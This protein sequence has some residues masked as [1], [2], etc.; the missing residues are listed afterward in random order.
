MYII[1]MQARVGGT[2]AMQFGAV[3]GEKTAV[4]SASRLHVTAVAQALDLAC[5]SLLCPMTPARV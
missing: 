2:C 1:C 3:T 4:G 5:G